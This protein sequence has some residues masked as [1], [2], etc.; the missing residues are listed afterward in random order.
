MDIRA[1]LLGS[2]HLIIWC[3]F[4][5]DQMMSNERLICK[6]SIVKVR[7]HAFMGLYHGDKDGAENRVLLHPNCH[8]QVHSQKLKVAK[9][10]S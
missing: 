1:K 3:L 4:S 2:V 8:N 9:P 5:H 6:S 7:Y 10:R